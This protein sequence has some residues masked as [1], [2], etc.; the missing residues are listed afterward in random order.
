MPNTMIAKS[1]F[2]VILLNSNGDICI[3][4][5]GDT[6]I[7]VYKIKGNAAYKKN[8]YENLAFQIVDVFTTVRGNQFAM[9]HDGKSFYLTMIAKVEDRS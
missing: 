5:D 6:P 1:G 3:L 8:K 9:W 4:Q 7:D 2:R